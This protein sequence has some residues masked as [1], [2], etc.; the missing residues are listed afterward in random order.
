MSEPGFV[1]D[2]F[3]SY[4]AKDKAVVRLLAER[5]RADELN[6]WF[7]E[8]VLKPGDSIPAKNE[9]GLEHSRVHGAMPVGPGVRVGL[10]AVEGLPHTMTTLHIRQEAAGKKRH[11]IRLTVKCLV[12][13]DIETGATT[14]FSHCHR[15]LLR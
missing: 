5:L 7:D 1:H 2:V 12:V 6:V 15:T 4:S 13:T 10:G 8:W 11:R 14:T 3:L 9:E